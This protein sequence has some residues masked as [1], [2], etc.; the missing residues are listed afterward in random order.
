MQLTH[1][2]LS[3]LSISALNM[4]HARKPP[5]TGDILP[6]VRARGILVPLLVRPNG[7]ADTF[8]IVAGRRRYH[9]ALTVQ[10]E[11]GLTMELPCAVMEATDNAA[12]LEASLL[13]NY[14]REQP[15]EVELWESFTRLVKAG[16]S[17]HEVALA[18]SLSERQVEQ[19]LALG[20]L[21]PRIRE[22]YR[23]EDL[24][25]A[26]V[27][28]LTM[29]G[30]GRQKE[31]LALHSDPNAHAPVGMRLKAWLFG[32]AS[33]PASVAIFDLATYP[34]EIVTDLF[35]EERYFADS[36]RFWEAQRAAVEEKRQ[37][38]LAQGWTDVV[39]LEPGSY[40]SSWDHEKV[41]RKKGGK[42]FIAL[43]Q[44]GEVAFHEGYLTRAEARRKASGGEE[45][46]KV[47]RPELTGPLTNYADLHRHAAVRTALL[48][49]PQVALRLMAAHA[50]SGSYFFTVRPD[51]QRAA[52]D[53]IAESVETC[54]SE[55]RFD[56]ARREALAAL[57]LDGETPTLIQNHGGHGEVDGTAGLFLR[58]LDMSDE[59]VLG[60]VAVIMG[61]ALEA[62]SAVIEA[63]GF[64]LGVDMSKVWQADDALFGLLRD[65]ELLLA[66]VDELA[67]KEAAAGNA[68]EKASGLRAIVRDCLSGGNGRERV[69]GW[70]PR[71]MRFP[72]AAYTARGGV[73][74]VRQFAA[75]APLIEARAGRPAAPEDAAGGAPESR[76]LATCGD[77]PETVAA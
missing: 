43:S 27:R 74:T 58:L 30:R 66:M 33:I 7:S 64:H 6:S 73:G 13:E 8:E 37:A 2:D 10:E 16:R 67:G 59:Q 15:H 75:I 72:P 50:L 69:H 34:H 68:K 5:D 29:A 38:D 22:L 44:R 45:A 26:S 31:W 9:A 20:N 63:L 49:A 19:I 14:A 60:I 4:R 76:P 24:D 61:E 65:R 21:L 35:G 39:L 28:L 70:V 47:Q 55:T 53:A 48:G 18:F 12:A 36:E 11:S 41:P 40:F 23:R 32:G 52:T 3:K 57:G 62:G 1:I 54:P 56:A 42:V 51:P 77:A 46:E 71:F 17:P 25:T